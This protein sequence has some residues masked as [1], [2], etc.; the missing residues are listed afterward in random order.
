LIVNDRAD[1]ALASDADGVHLGQEDLPLPAARRLMGERTIGIS[2]HNA[3]QARAA[4]AGGADYVGFG[5]VFGTATKDTGYGARG[6]EML[7]Q[8][9]GAVKLPIVAIG[10]IN[11]RNV[12]QV[13]RAGADA[14]A[15]I[16]DIL[17]ADDIVGKTT[18]IIALGGKS[19][20]SAKRS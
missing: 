1:I 4:E 20:A 19:A 7:G 9:R 6:L 2:T 3:D 12:V 11:E 15:I 5:P 16:S 17:G 14:A 13:W 10:G 18:R 8:V